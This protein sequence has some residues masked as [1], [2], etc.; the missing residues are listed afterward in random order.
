MKAFLQTL[1]VFFCFALCGLIAF[2]WLR[3]ARLRAE[4]QPLREAA[5]RSSNQARE[6]SERVRGLQ[7]EL[8]RLEQENRE[9]AGALQS[10]RLDLAA[11]RRR[12]HQ[13]NDELKVQQRVVDTLRAALEEANRSIQELNRSLREQ[14]DKLKALAADRDQVVKQYN[15]IVRHYNELVERTAALP[16]PSE[17]PPAAA[18]APAASKP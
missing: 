10:N 18:G 17:P 5:D 12:H 11:A 15:E 1:L 7:A 14:R 3:E 9:L 2:Q 16:S 8:Q 6:L 13:A 4:L